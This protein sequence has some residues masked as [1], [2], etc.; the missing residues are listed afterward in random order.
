MNFSFQ[1]L[2]D[3]FR[4]LTAEFTDLP[5]VPHADKLTD[6]SRSKRIRRFLKAYILLKIF[7]QFKLES[8]PKIGDRILWIYSGKNPI[9]GSKPIGDSLMDLSGRALLKDKYTIDL[10]TFSNI[11]D[12]LRYDDIFRHV[13]SDIS[14]IDP[15]EYD[16][17][18][19]TGYTPRAIRLKLTHFYKKR[20]GSL[21]RFLN[22][23]GRFNQ[24][25]YSYHA[26]NQLF[27]LKHTIEE[28]NSIARPYFKSG[29]SKFKFKKPY[30]C[31][32]IG[33]Q[34][35]TRIYSQWQVVLD[36]L[37]KDNRLNQMVVFFIR[38]K[39]WVS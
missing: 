24:I 25:L 21:F 9:R 29:K 36:Q 33:G 13:Y 39:K 19:F 16:Y 32:S 27:G 22:I 34:D 37:D 12:L 1:G 6:V 17:I 31:L 8:Q 3:R 38:L 20:F 26:V 15:D 23:N 4:Q 18:L 11:V 35:A 5:F 30:I 2:Q 10:L 7:D 28:V 14:S